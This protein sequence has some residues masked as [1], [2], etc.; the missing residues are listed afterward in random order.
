MQHFCKEIAM[1][2][3]EAVL[4]LKSTKALAATLSDCIDTNPWAE[5]VLF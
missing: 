2:V 1:G 3:S 5:L 4:E